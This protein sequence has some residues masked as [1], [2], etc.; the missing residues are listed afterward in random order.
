MTRLW[1]NV[2]RLP[3]R[4]AASLRRRCQPV[5]R[6]QRR[7]DRYVRAHLSAPL[8]RRLGDVP[9]HTSD[10]QCRVIFYLAMTT[11]ADGVLVEIGAY[12]GR[13]TA[14]L[15]EAARRGARH[16]VSIDPHLNDSYER[17]QQTL[18]EFDIENVATL[19]RATSQEVGRSFAQPIALLWVDGGH[20]YDCVRQDIADFTP[21]VR[22]GGIALFD[23][24]NPRAFPG[25]VRAIDESLRRDRTWVYLGRIKMM[26]VWERVERDKG[27]KTSD[28]ATEPSRPMRERRKLSSPSTDVV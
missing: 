20:D 15:A 22:P 10:R 23:D 6:I 11:P 26:D 14:W 18:R 5:Y 24:A 3:V 2:I 1:R 16:L 17:F 27:L 9:G 28:G 21:R 7:A 12:K 8:I 13:S 25:V 4:T 19:H